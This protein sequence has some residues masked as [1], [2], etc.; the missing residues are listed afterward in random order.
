KGSL[1]DFEQPDVAARLAAPVSALGDRG[2][3]TREEIRTRAVVDR[4]QSRAAQD[5]REESGGGGLPIRSRHDYAAVRGRAC[6]VPHGI[7]RKA[8][9]RVPGDAGPAAPPEATAQPGRRA[10][11]QQGRTVSRTHR[12]PL[13]N[14]MRE[15]VR[16]LRLVE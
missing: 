3:E 8:W 10:A 15:L 13:V 12:R 2:E 7:R 6:D 9:N 11:R 1:V 5:V 16:I 14:Y 4:S